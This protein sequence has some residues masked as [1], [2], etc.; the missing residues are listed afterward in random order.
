M[1]KPPG[2][3]HRPPDH[4]IAQVPTPASDE[5]TRLIAGIVITLTAETAH[6]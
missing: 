6:A 2:F 1:A 4:G 5:L 3:Y